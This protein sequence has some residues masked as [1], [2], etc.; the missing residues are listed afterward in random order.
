[1]VKSIDLSIAEVFN[2][3]SALR[4]R[5]SLHQAEKIRMQYVASCNS[6]VVSTEM[7]TH[8]QVTAPF[9]LMQTSVG[10]RP[11]LHPTALIPV[12]FATKAR[13][14][15]VHRQETGQDTESH[16]AV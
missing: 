11:G 8:A 13:F 7:W 14:G 10:V 2:S 6:K 1:M 3:L 5:K 12:L 4:L 15:I 16:L 9:V